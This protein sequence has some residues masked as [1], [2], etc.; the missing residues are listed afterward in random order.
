LV[1]N[2][3][4]AEIH[5]QQSIKIVLDLINCKWTARF[6]PFYAGLQVIQ[7]LT[8]TLHSKLSI[9]TPST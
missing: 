1:I 6:S 8:R 5:G 4:Y 3:N 7:V 9:Y 2:N